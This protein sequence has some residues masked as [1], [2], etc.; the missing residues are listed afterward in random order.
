MNGVRGAPGIFRNLNDEKLSRRKAECFPSFF[1]QYIQNAGMREENAQKRGINNTK[2]QKQKGAE[3]MRYGHIPGIDHKVSRILFGT[4]QPLFSEGGDA[5]ALLDA[6]TGLGINF[7]DTARVYGQSED[8]IGR[9]MRVRRNRHQVILLT[10]CSHPLPD[11]TRRVNPTEIRSD[12]ETSLKKLRT[13]YVDVLVLHRDDPSVD[14]GEIVECCNA[15]IHEGKIRAYGGSNW[16]HERIAAAN[17]YAASNGLQ[18]LSVSSPNF[19]LARQV[20]DPWGGDCVSI[21]GK[22]GEE[23]QAW[24]RENQLPVISYSSLARGFLSGRVHGDDETSGAKVLDSFAVRGFDWPENYERLRRCERLSQLRG[25]TVP[26]IALAWIFSQGINAFAVVGTSST[27][28]MQQNLVALDIMLS[29]TEL[30]ELNLKTAS[31][32]ER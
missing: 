2:Q 29:Q 15:L 10:K 27:E 22:E 14:V 1:I 32:E 12:L 30:D 4:A 17:A 6:M 26:Q 5:S 21:S 18:P 3:N 20:V 16:T 24:Y 25:V 8:T 31:P 9:W 23:A 19:S 28:R 11:G 13:D 7:L